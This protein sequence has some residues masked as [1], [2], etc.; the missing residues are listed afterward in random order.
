VARFLAGCAHVVDASPEEVIEI[1]RDA[2]GDAYDERS[3]RL[4]LLSGVVWLGWNKALDIG[5][6]ADPAV[7]AR[8]A[9]SLTWWLARAEE[10]LETD[11]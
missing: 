8:E 7:R 6:H 1:Y 10:A 9:A 2:A 11:L 3:M 4:A 5:E